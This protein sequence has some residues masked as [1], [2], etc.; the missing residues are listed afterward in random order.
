MVSGTKDW[1]KRVYEMLYSNLLSTSLDYSNAAMVFQYGQDTTSLRMAVKMMEE[2]IELNPEMNKW[3]L[4]AA[5]GRDLMR[6]DKPQIYVT[7]YM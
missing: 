5:I 3:L 4:A 6:R 7:L 2:T 1:Q